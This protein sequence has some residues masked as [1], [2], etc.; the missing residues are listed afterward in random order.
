M[1]IVMGEGHADLHDEEGIDPRNLDE[2]EAD[3]LQSVIPVVDARYRTLPDRDHRAICGLSMGGIQSLSTGLRHL[4]T[5]AWIGGM[6]AWLPEAE[7][8]CGRL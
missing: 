1:L 7:A 4:E 8:R 6:S 3:L 5:F 2:W